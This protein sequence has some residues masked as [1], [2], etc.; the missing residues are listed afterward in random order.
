MDTKQ[1]IATVNKLNTKLSDLDKKLTGTRIELDDTNSKIAEAQQAL[2]QKAKSLAKLIETRQK[3][4]ENLNSKLVERQSLLAEMKTTKYPKTVDRAKSQE[5][6]Q[7]N[8]QAGEIKQDIGHEQ[9]LIDNAK[10]ISLEEYVV[11]RYE[12]EYGVRYPQFAGQYLSDDDFKKVLEKL[13]EQ[14]KQIDNPSQIVEE[15]LTSHPNTVNTQQVEILKQEANF[16]R[17]K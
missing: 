14:M 12:K 6:I 10:D 5:A 7:Y 1:L 8:V 9:E 4:L 17:T 3:E 11:T 15:Y 13:K 16:L 2:E